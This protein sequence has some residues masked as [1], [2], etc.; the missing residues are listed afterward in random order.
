MSQCVGGAFG[1][2]DVELVFVFG[3][4][5]AGDVVDVAVG[6]DREAVTVFSRGGRR[7]EDADDAHGQKHR[8]HEGDARSRHH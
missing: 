4:V 7:R 2:E 1:H 3:V 5:F 6:H 8:T